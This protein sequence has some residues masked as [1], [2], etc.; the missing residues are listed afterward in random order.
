MACHFIQTTPY[1]SK[2]YSATIVVA[3]VVAVVH[4]RCTLCRHKNCLSRNSGS[5]CV[6]I[7][8]CFVCLLRL[9][10][11]R[12]VCAGRF[13]ARSPDRWCRLLCNGGTGGFPMRRRQLAFIFCNFVRFYKSN[14]WYNYWRILH[15]KTAKLVEKRQVDGSCLNETWLYVCSMTRPVG[16]VVAL[17]NRLFLCCSTLLS[18]ARSYVVF[19]ANSKDNH[20][21]EGNVAC[22]YLVLPAVYMRISIRSLVMG[23]G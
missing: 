9:C 3:V 22:W 2:C 4:P 21:P 16:D 14:N 5:A 23:V 7:K 11:C 13:C 20:S 1:K 19:I 18:M 10:S 6:L 8:C 17:F 15:R 12:R